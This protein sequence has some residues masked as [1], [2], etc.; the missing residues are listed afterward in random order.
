MESVRPFGV[1]VRLPGFQKSGLVHSTHVAE[2]MRFGV[3]DVDDDK[4]KAMEWVCPV[5]EQVW[6]KVVE[7]TED[8]M[9]GPK[10]ACSIKVVDQ[11]DGCAAL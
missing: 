9:R 1:F 4:V 11:A 10:V 3:D 2:D 6:V 7:V 5:G 8:P